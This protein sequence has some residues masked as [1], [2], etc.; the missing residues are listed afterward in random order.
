MKSKRYTTEG[1]IRILREAEAVDESIL[2]ICKEKGISKQTLQRWKRE[3]GIMR[4]DQ[5]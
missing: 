3:F 2:Q 5:T 4:L 1:R